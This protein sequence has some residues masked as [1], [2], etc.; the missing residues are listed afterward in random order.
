MRPDRTATPILLIGS[1]SDLGVMRA[2]ISK[3]GF[4]SI[5]CI[6]DGSK[7]A[8]ILRQGGRMLVIADLRIRPVSGLDVLRDLRADA[9]LRQT[10]FIMTAVELSFEEALQI[11]RAGADSLLLR[12]FDAA[13]LASKIEKALA[14]TGH[15]R[16]AVDSVPTKSFSAVVGRRNS[17]RFG[18][19]AE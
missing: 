4:G 10:P 1:E 5:R 12:P 8:D 9:S 16:A 17:R 14:C 19:D 2:V 13:A 6:C 7:T 3:L 18:F 11:K 15:I